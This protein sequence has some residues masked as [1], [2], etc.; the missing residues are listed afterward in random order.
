M[1]LH[2]TQGYDF[3]QKQ[4]LQ[5]RSIVADRLKS[6]HHY[7]LLVIQDLKKKKNYDHIGI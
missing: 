3:L 5:D 4:L 1:L 6:L 7:Y 2:L